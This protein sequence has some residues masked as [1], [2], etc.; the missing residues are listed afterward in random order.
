[1]AQTTTGAAFEA[2]HPRS[3]DGTFATKDVAEPADG[4]AA[5]TLADQA[6]T[7][8]PPL[9]GADLLDAART[10]VRRIRGRRTQAAWVRSQDD[11]MVG[12]VV[13]VCLRR[14]AKEGA[15]IHYGYV[16]AVARN[17][18]SRDRDMAS[19][20]AKAIRLLSARINDLEQE[21]HRVASELQVCQVAEQILAEWPEGTR[22]PSATFFRRTQIISL[23][24]SVESG[25]SLVELV[26]DDSAGFDPTGQ[27]VEQTAEPDDAAVY[28]LLDAHE[29][30]TGKA[31]HAAVKRAAWD[32]LAAATGAPRVTAK[33]SKNR[34]TSARTLFTRHPEGP[35][36]AVEAALATWDRADEDDYTAAL[37]APFDTADPDERAGV[38]A[39]LRMS[40]PHAGDLWLAALAAANTSHQ[41]A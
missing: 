8:D 11:D 15:P 27:A 41:A 38:V 21:Q 16:H 12:D 4:L 6:E 23:D 20:D 18:L 37:F 19:V 9:S 10:A 17:L 36:G 30:A 39:Q 13:E 40:G 34:V 1:M 7:D 2:L 35:I 32:A 14:Q 31:E 33:L 29:R 26:N 28:D 3:T 24:A 25:S 22:R 5:L